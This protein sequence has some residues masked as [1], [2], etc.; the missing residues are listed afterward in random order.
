M[1]KTEHQ[2]EIWE[3]Q[4]R[5]EVKRD[6]DS[7]ADSGKEARG[8]GAETQRHRD[9]ARESG[10]DGAEGREA[11]RDVDQNNRVESPE[12]VIHKYRQMILDKEAKAIQC[13]KD[14]VFNK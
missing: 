11:S 2:R 10:G 12:I 9:R 14:S 13:R 1:E 4:R 8:T 3:G 7:H 6:R 5:R